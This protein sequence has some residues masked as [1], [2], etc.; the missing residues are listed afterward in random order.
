MTRAAVIL[1]I[2]VLSGVAAFAHPGYVAADAA[3]DLQAQIDAHNSQISQL[4]ADIAAYQKQL[5]QLAAKKNSLNSALTGFTV[6]AK[7]LAS[8]IKVTQNKMSAAQLKIEQLSG[9]I[10]DKEATID[11][12]K[13]AIGKMLRAIAEQEQMPLIATLASAD[14]LAGAWQAADEASQLNR[15][16]AQD[17]GELRGVQVALAADRDKVA[18]QKDQLASLTT[19]LTTQK[20]SVDANAATQKQL[21]KQTSNQEASYQRLIAQKKA[22]EQQFEQE[23]NQLQSQLNLIVHPGSLP[24][25]GKGVINWPFSLAFMQS[26]GNRKSVFGNPYCITQYFGNTPFA[27]A[28]PQIYNGHGHNAIDIAAPIGTPVVA[29]LGGTV[30]GTGNTDLSHNSKGQQCYSFGKWVM[31]KHGNGINT[32]YAHLSQIEVSQGQA[33]TG[34]QVIGLSGMTGY[35]T[36]PHLH[37]GVYATDGTEIMDLGAHLGTSDGPCSKAV[38]PIATLDAYLN[39]LSYL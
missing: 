15:S 19:D 2:L 16:L 4:E 21:I 11:S 8:Q 32:M 9:T 33:V 13:N 14:S 30:L 25:V 28:N 1:L 18:S 5:D 24:A 10:S 26:C 23:L 36:G 17:I 12:D 37:F 29:A 39:P 6:T 3:S 31:I 22:A 38:M 27:T 20:K 35:A 34:G 7:Q